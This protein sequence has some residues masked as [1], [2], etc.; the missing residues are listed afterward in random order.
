M[1]KLSIVE[2][3]ARATP[4]A[5]LLIFAVYTFSNTRMNKKNYLL[6]SFLM[7]IMIFI[8]RSL[9]ISYGIHTILS[10]M[11]L[12]LLSYIINRIDVIRAV[13][14]TIITI[15]FQ[16]I[17][18]GTNIFIIQYILKK[19]MNHIFRDPNLKTIYGIPSLIIFA[20]I[21]VLRYIRLLKRKELQYD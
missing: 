14:S 20:C 21:I 19:D 7:L 15:I 2:F 17:C 6:S 1:L 11:V 12:I 9:P 10:I 16:L 8:I 18:E 13:K 3:V 4:E 5:F